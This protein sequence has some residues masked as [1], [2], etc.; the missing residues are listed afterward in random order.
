MSWRRST[1]LAWALVCLVTVLLAVGLVMRAAWGRGDGNGML[2]TAVTSAALL[3]C[4]VMGALVV[5]RVSGNAVGW[6]LLAIAILLAGN[7]VVGSYARHGLID[8]PGSLPGALAA[9]WAFTFLWFPTVAA[10]IA[11]PLL[12]PTGRVPGPRWRWVGW[13]LAGL[14]VASVVGMALYPGRVGQAKKPWPENPLG[15]EALRPIAG[16]LMPLVFGSLALLALVTVASVVVRFRRSRGDEREQLKW[17]LY[18]VVV[19]VAVPV[20]GDLGYPAAADFVFAVAMLLV[21]VA[22]GVAMM[23]YRLYDVDRVIS[24][25]LVYGAVTALLGAAYAGLVLLGQAVS[26]S[27]AGGG[28][29]VIAV[30]TLVVAALFLPLRRRIQ[31]FVDRRFY[32]RRYDAEATVAAFGARL[33]EQVDL[34]ELTVE[35]RKVVGETMQPSSASLWL[36][37]PA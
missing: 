1:S 22:V 10:V 24:K 12:F 26:S 6:L 8:H 28:S 33:R 31:R 19:L 2:T 11:V 9:G 13:G 17:M 4:A 35:L 27:V 34:D 23:R 25:T 18:S 29:L 30:S 7:A 5:S 20:V 14:C 16:V 32:R 3:S 37:E 21:P 36:R 15:I